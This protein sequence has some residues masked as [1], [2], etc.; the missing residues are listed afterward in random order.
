MSFPYELLIFDSVALVPE[1]YLGT[2][3]RATSYREI[4]SAKSGRLGVGLFL[5]SFQGVAQLALSVDFL[6]PF[7]TLG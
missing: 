1:F 7:K 6:E 4:I 3:G 2:R 5:E